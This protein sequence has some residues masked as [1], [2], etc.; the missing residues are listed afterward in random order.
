MIT[1]HKVKERFGQTIENRDE[2]I[3][4]IAT[5]VREFLKNN[6]YD[7]IVFPE[8]SS[9]FI[10][11]TVKMTGISFIKVFKNDISNI[12]EYAN[13]MKLQKMERKSHLERI[14]GMGQ[15]FKINAL[16]ATQRNKYEDCLFKKTNIPEGKGIIIDDSLFSGTTFRALQNITEIKDWLAIFSK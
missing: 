4:E 5:L 10:E 8:S 9:D 3:K 12:M 2:F 13:T 11:Q 16:K 7:F 15:K 6:G 1:Y 14:E